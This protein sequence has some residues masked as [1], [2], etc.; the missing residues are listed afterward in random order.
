MPTD[1]KV[2]VFTTSEYEIL[3]ENAFIAAKYH[4]LTE[5]VQWASQK[6]VCRAKLNRGTTIQEV[7]NIES[8][9]GDHF[10]AGS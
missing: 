3:K 10:S 7:A 5:K 2:Q 1:L 9:A 4:E 8:C 6:Q